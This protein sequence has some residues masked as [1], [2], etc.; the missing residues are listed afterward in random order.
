MDWVWHLYEAYVR[1][2]LRRQG[3]NEPSQE[4]LQATF[5]SIMSES[6]VSVLVQE[7]WQSAVRFKGL[8]KYDATLM[9]PLLNDPMGYLVAQYGGG[10]FKL[11]FHQGLNFIATKN[12]KPEGEPRWKELPDIGY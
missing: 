11:N 7:P 6:T 2:E 10:K 12:F 9:M 4:Q 8:A 5:V 1:K 3:I